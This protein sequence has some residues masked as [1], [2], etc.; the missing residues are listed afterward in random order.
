M[1]R[2]EGIRLIEGPT[3]RPRAG[4]TPSELRSLGAPRR[5]DLFDHALSGAI[6]LGLLGLVGA[7]C[8]G[9][10]LHATIGAAAAAATSSALGLTLLGFGLLVALRL[11]I[12]TGLWFRYRPFDSA[13]FDDAP[14]LT[15]IIPAY[16]EGPM[17]ARSIESVL[18]AAYPRDRLEVFVVDD[19]SKDDTWTHIQ[20]AAARFPGLVTT[21]RFEKNRGKRAALEEGFRRAKGEVLVTIDSDSVI[22]RQTLLAAAGPFR[23]PRVGAVAGRVAVHNRSEGPIP[24]ML[25]VAFTLS[26][27]F[28]RATQS[29][30]GTVYCC[31]GA[32]TA[33]RAS[34]VRAALDAWSKQSFLGVPCPAGEDRA[35]T[36]YVLAQGLDTVY[37]RSAVVHTVVPTTYSKLCKMYLRWDRSYIREELRLAWILWRRPPVA[38]ALTLF[39]AVLR[40]L[41]YPLR[42]LTVFLVVAA[43]VV[44]PLVLLTF[45]GAITLG[46]LFRMLYFLRCERSSSFVWGVAYAFYYLFGLTWIFPYALVTVRARGWLTR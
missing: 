37:Q 41:S 8:A 39:D 4:Q 31:P 1:V 9:L 22:E 15:I 23:D 7:A 30:Y 34:A 27:D 28:H 36:N 42:Y 29:Q 14:A 12:Q 6:V 2:D 5:P 40:N 18:S 35:M 19:G 10:G 45:A 21:V 46:A 17:V 32:L 33:L 26:F 25:H 24:Q 11:V 13:T 43:A 3:A 38:L 16:N 44:E 20:R